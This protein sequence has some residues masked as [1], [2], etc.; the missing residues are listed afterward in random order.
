MK[1]VPASFWRNC[2]LSIHVF[3]AGKGVSPQQSFD[4]YL[5]YIYG[6]VQGNIESKR[7]LVWIPSLLS[8]G[9]V[10]NAGN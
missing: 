5:F 3:R 2:K 8:Y 6:V 10:G 4:T 9:K 1:G 7:L